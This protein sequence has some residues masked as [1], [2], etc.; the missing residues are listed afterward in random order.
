MHV[1]LCG[2]VHDEE[3]EGK[4]E[5]LDDLFHCPDCGQRKSAYIE[6]E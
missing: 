1:C 4:W 5:E 3:L 6:V 2:H